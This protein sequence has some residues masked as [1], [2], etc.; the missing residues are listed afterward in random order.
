MKAKVS[1]ANKSYDVALPQPSIISFH[2]KIRQY[3]S[4]KAKESFYKQPQARHH[5]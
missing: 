1:K 2:P 3:A 4:L 5:I